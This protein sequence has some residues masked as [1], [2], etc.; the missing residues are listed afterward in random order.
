LPAGWTY[1]AAAQIAPAQQLTARRRLDRHLNGQVRQM[2]DALVA[3]GAP[4]V[5]V[6]RRQ[7]AGPVISLA[8][9]RI[10]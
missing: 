2:Q 4:R 9:I 6:G 1:S 8:I 5:I 10:C 7:L 3:V